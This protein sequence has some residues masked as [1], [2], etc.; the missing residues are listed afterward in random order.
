MY[1]GGQAVFQARSRERQL[2]AAAGGL[3][4]SQPGD[5]VL[6]LRRE[7]LGT[8]SEFSGRKIEPIP[9]TVN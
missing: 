3:F 6:A 5:S 4:E 8:K 9:S 1:V 2:L 7:A